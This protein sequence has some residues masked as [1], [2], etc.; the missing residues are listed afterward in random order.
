MPGRPK[1]APVDPPAPAVEDQVQ[2]NHAALLRMLA[3]IR[4]RVPELGPRELYM[5]AALAGYNANPDPNVSNADPG[6]KALWAEEDAR[7]LLEVKSDQ[8]EAH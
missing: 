7:A 2:A 5:A 8:V 6:S 4:D 3:K 1:D